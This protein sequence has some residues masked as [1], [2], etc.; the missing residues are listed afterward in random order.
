MRFFDCYNNT[1]AEGDHIGWPLATGQ[2]APGKILKLE[3]GLALPNGQ[4]PP[5]TVVLVIELHL[6][7]LPNGAVPQIIKAASPESGLV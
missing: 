4:Q 5:P 3:S 7:A 1:L 6:T 2:I